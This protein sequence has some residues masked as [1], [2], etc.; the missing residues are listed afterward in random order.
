MIRTL[1]LY[2]NIA[3]VERNR[4]LVVWPKLDQSLKSEGK[5]SYAQDRFNGSDLETLAI[6]P[7]SLY[8]EEEIVLETI[9]WLKVKPYNFD[10]LVAEDTPLAEKFFHEVLLQPPG[11]RP[12]VLI[13]LFLSDRES[14]GDFFGDQKFFG[15][16]LNC[17]RDFFELLLLLTYSP[18]QEAVTARSPEELQ[19]AIRDYN[20]W[21]PKQI[22][23]V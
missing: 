18:F 15:L 3:P 21:R 12:F 10:C 1:Y 6:Y 7:Y 23:V 14:I 16:K 22:L 4:R 8:K 17:P 20:I 13:R 2:Q 9:D 19:K 11:K 5:I